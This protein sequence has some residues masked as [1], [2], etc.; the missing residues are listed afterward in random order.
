MRSVLVRHVALIVLG[1]FPVLAAPSARAQ[2]SGLDCSP[3]GGGSL[4]VFLCPVDEEIHTG[5]ALRLGQLPEAGRRQQG[6][7]IIQ[8]GAGGDGAGIFAARLVVDVKVPW[9]GAGQP[10][11][12]GSISKLDLYWVQGPM[13]TI[14]TQVKCEYGSSDRTYTILQRSGLTCNGAPYDF[15]VYSL[16]AVVCPGAGS[17]EKRTDLNGMPLQ[18][19]AEMLGCPD[20][21]KEACNGDASCTS[22]LAGGAGA[23]GAPPGFGGPG[24][25][26]TGPGATLRYT[27]KGVGHPGYPG[28]ADW[29]RPSGATGA[30]TTPCGSSRTRT[31]STSGL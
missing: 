21:P 24:G 13:A 11:T 26:R 31:R 17:C 29:T 7:E 28:T 14:F 1:L 30:T 6:I 2:T 22:C 4:P 20:P 10:T 25:P 9:N 8:T 15:G 19:T 27:A 16:R 23:G 3:C 12:G 18:V 5:Q